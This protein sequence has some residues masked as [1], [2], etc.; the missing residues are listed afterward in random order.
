VAVSTPLRPESARLMTELLVGVTAA[1]GTGRRAAVPG[2]RVAGKTGTAV[3]AGVGGYDN[4]R[5]IASFMGLIPAE[6][7]A[8]AI[9]VVVDEPQPEHT[10][11]VVAAPVFRQIAYELVRYLGIPPSA[12]TRALEEVESAVLPEGDSDADWPVM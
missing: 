2:Y 1:E 5:N 4:R 12:G 11:G 3:K 10:G 7:P 9:I 8:L 6:S